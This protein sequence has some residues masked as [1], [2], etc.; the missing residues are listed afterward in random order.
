MRKATNY[1]VKPSELKLLPPPGTIDGISDYFLKETLSMEINNLRQIGETARQFVVKLKSLEQ[2]MK[3]THNLLQGLESSKRE[4]NKNLLLKRGYQKRM[5]DWE[6]TLKDAYKFI[7][8]T[9]KFFTNEKLEYLILFDESLS[10]D[11]TNES[12][13]VKLSMDQLLQSVSLNI[14]FDNGGIRLKINRQDELKKLYDNLESVGKI[15]DKI[16]ENFNLVLQKR[17]ATYIEKQKE[18][19]ND[20][21]V[22]QA[23]KK[24][25]LSKWFTSR[26]FAFETAVVM[27]AKMT[28]SVELY[29]QDTDAF[30][31]G[32]DLKSAL[33]EIPK[34]LL[35]QGERVNYELKRVSAT[36]KKSIGAGLVSL[37]S[38][39]TALVTIQNVLL[40]PNLQKKEMQEVLNNY[41]F[42]AKQNIDRD[43]AEALG[44]A[45]AEKLN[46][47]IEEGLS[48]SL[49]NL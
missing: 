34:D 9:R 43:F 13:V 1:Q 27:A 8:Q 10:G 30:W 5:L 38:L 25:I 45:T 4:L 33:N 37:N 2:W 29:K 39:I 26:G 36:A 40:N 24:K 35:S 22:S 28:N 20:S 3:H 44:T 32:G 15:S 47:I 31:R 14:D 21:T 17:W 48:W 11:K 12:K 18:L 6:R 16:V 7:Q 41:L 49:E 19:E 46:K 23:E 42:K